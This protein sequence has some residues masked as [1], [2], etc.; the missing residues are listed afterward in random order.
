MRNLLAFTAALILTV[1]GVGWY[2]DWY[3]LGSAPAPDGHQKVTIDVNTAK[4]SQDV[5]KAEQ[6]LEHKLSETKSAQPATK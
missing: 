2:L 3:R 5:H 6:G 4:I 1:L